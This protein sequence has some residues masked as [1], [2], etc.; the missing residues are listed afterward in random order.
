MRGR[1]RSRDDEDSADDAPTRRISRSRDDDPADNAP[2]R[3]RSRS[4]DDP[5]VPVPRCSAQTPASSSH[6]QLPKTEQRTK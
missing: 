5:Q 6:R 4:S 2:M 1:S 3:G